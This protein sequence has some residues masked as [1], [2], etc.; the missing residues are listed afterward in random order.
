MLQCRLYLSL[1]LIAIPLSQL[2]GQREIVQIHQANPQYICIIIDHDYH[3]N[4][5]FA[6]P[7]TYKL[8]Y[9]TGNMS[10]TAW[11]KSRINDRWSQL[12]AKKAGDFYNGVEVNRIDADNQTV[13]ISASFTEY[14]DSLFLQVTD[15]LNNPVPV[16]YGGICSYYDNRRAVVTVSCDDWSDWV[17]SDNR[18]PTLLNL[19]RQYHQ[20]VTVAIITN[21]DN[22]T[23]ATWNSLQTQLNQGYIEVASHSRSH[24]DTPYVDYQGEINGSYD[25]II[26]H[27]TL[28]AL[29]TLGAKEYVYVWIAP[30]GSYNNTIDSLLQVKKYLVPR[31]YGIGNNSIPSATFSNWEN[32]TKHFAAI[33]PVVEI[34]APSWGGGDSSLS[35]L[36][37]RFDSILAVKGIYHFMWHPQVIYP[38]RAKPYLLNH[39]NYISNRTDLWYANLGHIYLYH[40]LQSKATLHTEE[41]PGYQNKPGD[42]YLEQNFPNPFN[43]GTRIIYH[44]VKGGKVSL[45]I[46]NSL[47]QEVST[48]VNEYKNA[49]IYTVDFATNGLASGVY[50][51]QLR[52]G[53]NIAVKRMMK[54]K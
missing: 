42:F 33:N 13:Y 24:P 32:N 40:L 11:K 49:G 6:Y 38:D 16:Q 54:L 52:M 17:V 48:L 15:S 53:N 1:A 25:D 14:S 35:S 45:K 51:C 37:S 50:L 19:F 36:N 43:P 41:S 27:L 21:N 46:F 44:V 29:F 7:V 31:L 3:I 5:G 30:Y 8:R 2:F 20:Y 39:L 4:Y 26:S 47:G 10:L 28:P 23:Q 22:S 34:G 18:F 12:P 9:N